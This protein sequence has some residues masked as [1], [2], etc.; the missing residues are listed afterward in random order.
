VGRAIVEGLRDAGYHVLVH[1]HRSDPPAGADAVRADLRQEAQR[2]A[3]VKTVGPLHLL[4]NNAASFERGAFADRTDADLRRV[5]E[6]NLV[7][8]L[9]LIRGFLPALRASQGCVVN[10]L[11]VGG[12]QPWPG[13][14]DHCV[15]KAALQLAT[16]ALA[17]E[18]SPVRVVGVAPGTVAWP[19]GTSEATRRRI[20]EAIPR[21]R[22]GTPR[23]VAAAVV[24]LA[25]APH[26]NGTVLT[27][28]GGSLAAGRRRGD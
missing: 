17:V 28:D 16:Q 5:L 21:G 22:I 9:S 4:V 10:I 19:P 26:V 6:L 13:Y 8:P 27:V 1:H 7:A 11:D 15:S 20:E 23:D 3:L 24:F 25:D 12:T 2:R 14:V 18:L